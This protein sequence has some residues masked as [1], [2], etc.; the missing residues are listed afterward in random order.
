MRIAISGAG[1]AGTALA[2][3]LKRYGHEPVLI[4]KAPKLRTGG[5]VV[6]F[7]GLG[8]TITKRMGLLEKV[9]EQ[10]YLQREVRF[11]GNDNSRVGGFSTDII[12]QLTNGRFT[13]IRRGALVEMFFEALNGQVESIFGDQISKLTEGPDSI[14]VA[15]QHGG[16]REF[17]L[18]IGA[19]GLH[20]AVRGL[21]PG[22]ESK[23]ETY[24]G[25][26]VAAFEITG[27]RPRDEE[28]YIIHPTPSRQLARFAMRDDRTLF[29]FIFSCSPERA[30]MRMTIPEIRE[31]LREQFSDVG[32]EA[33]NILAMMEGVD[34]IY[35]DRMSQ[36]R[37]SCWHKGRVALVGDAAAAVSL[38]AGEGTGL[39]LIEAY[40]LAGEIARA[41]SD[42]T[43]AFQAY[44]ERLR[45]FLRDKQETSAASASA[46]VP[47]TKLGVW[48]RNQ[49]TKLIGIPGVASFFLGRNL[50][51]SLDLPEYDG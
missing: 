5:Y 43:R 14:S 9:M 21:S 8:L 31:L 41:G 36:I 20:S 46:F 42:Y 13:T 47:S 50:R 38:L 51:D 17:D 48:A 1:I 10:G 18:V 33:Q 25:Y 22:F 24:L 7:W 19:D 23:V 39:A 15:L 37:M 12:H 4:E 32:W 30:D 6:D 35:F 49:A 44:E 34:D 16:E 29:L 11:V 3:W 40:I 26:A 27:Y 28:I 2:Y 45:P